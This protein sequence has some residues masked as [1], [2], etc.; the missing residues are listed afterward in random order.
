LPTTGLAI[1]GTLKVSPTGPFDTEEIYQLRNLLTSP[2]H[3]LLPETF[4]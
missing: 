2:N 1:Q 3:Q 4:T